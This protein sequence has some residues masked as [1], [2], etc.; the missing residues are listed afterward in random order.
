MESLI[1]KQDKF[2]QLKKKKRYFFPAKYKYYC[3][4][5]QWWNEF[6]LLSIVFKACL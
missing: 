5:L 2:D 6:D 1:H 4:I 3:K